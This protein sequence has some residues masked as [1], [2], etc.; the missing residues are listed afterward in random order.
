MPA[1]KRPHQDR[2]SVGRTVGF[3][4]LLI[5]AVIVSWSRVQITPVSADPLDD[6]IVRCEPQ[7]IAGQVGRNDNHRSV[8]GKCRRPIR[9]RCASGLRHSHRPG[10]GC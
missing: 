4:I 6:A 5:V 9:R 3:V 10:G 8:C 7:V 1:S 2:K